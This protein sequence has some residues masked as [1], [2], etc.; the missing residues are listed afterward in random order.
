MQ[1]VIFDAFGTLVEI[2]DKRNPFRAAGAPRTVM[3]ENVGLE[4]FTQDP[5]LLADLRAEIASMALYG[6]VLST[7]SDLRAQ[8]VKLAVGSNLAKPYCAPLR[9]LL[10]RSVDHYHLSCEVGFMKPH[11][12]FFLDICAQ[13]GVHPED[14]VMI[15]DNYRNDYEG[16]E[17]AGLNA[18]MICRSLGEDLRG[19]LAGSKSLLPPSY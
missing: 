16:A 13:L 14:T 12:R 18:Q 1:A 7:L 6:D 10:G 8:G 3:T 2:M 11:S 17:A 5:A 15:G 19:I 9:A 4:H